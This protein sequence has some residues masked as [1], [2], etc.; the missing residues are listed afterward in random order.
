[1]RIN[2]KVWLAGTLVATASAIANAAVPPP[3]QT[4]H[5]V[6]G[7]MSNRPASTLTPDSYVCSPGSTIPTGV[8]VT[9]ISDRYDGNMLTPS[10]MT[11]SAPDLHTFSAEGTGPT[12]I[13]FT[14]LALDGAETYVDFPFTTASAANSDFIL[15]QA[16]YSLNQGTNY[17]SQFQIRMSLVDKENGNAEY[18]LGGTNPM[19]AIPR[20]NEYGIYFF[21]SNQA[22]PLTGAPGSSF[23]NCAEMQKYNDQGIANTVQTPVPL[24]PGSAYALR[25]YLSLQ[26]G[27]TDRR[28]MIDDVML[29]MQTVSV[30]AQNDGLL[31]GNSSDPAYTFTAQMGGTTGSVL[32]NDQINTAAVP[33]AN[34]TLTQVS[35]DAGLTLDTATGAINAAPGQPGAKTLTYQLCPKYDQAVVPNFQSSACKTAVAT[36]TLTGPAAPPSVSVT[37]TPN[38]LTDS[39][40]Q[41]STC[42]I[43]ADT[44]VTNALVV[45]LTPP[46]ASSRYQTDCASQITIAAGQAQASCTITATANTDP[47]D[48]NVMAALAITDNTALYTVSTR[49]ASVEVQNDDNVTPP[50]P[51][52]DATP[53]PS[54]QQAAIA[55][56][57]LLVAGLGWAG[58]RRRSV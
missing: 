23:V 27:A 35:A 33:A 36:V 21:V 50:Q 19:S 32:A 12:L 28:A 51:P 45:D 41:V 49:N 18:A 53:V 39:A 57:G 2:N 40:G 34:F 29:Y 43:T 38:V 20:L 42:T 13:P 1:M 4:N 22:W 31:A 6:A 26:A 8:A 30:D 3:T 11:F 10:A 37:C 24:K 54:L 7:W 56:L 47:V 15:N 58:L 5:N 17:G 52:A 55:L 14:N 25:A 48:G 46:T 44:T 16:F 9:P